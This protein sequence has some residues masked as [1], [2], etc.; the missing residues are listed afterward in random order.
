MSTYSQIIQLLNDNRDGVTN[1]DL[2]RNSWDGFETPEST[3]VERIDLDYNGG[4]LLM[5]M[6]KPRSDFVVIPTHEVD[7]PIVKF[8][9]EMNIPRLV[10]LGE[11]FE[12]LE[13]CYD[14][15][16]IEEGWAI[17]ELLTKQADV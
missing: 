13:T 14:G 3:I 1:L 9:K 11:I 6:V 15:L 16:S 8:A 4:L 17:D 7:F 2:I 5:I 12:K 10:K